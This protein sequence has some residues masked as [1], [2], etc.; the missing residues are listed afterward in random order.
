[1]DCSFTDLYPEHI[2]LVASLSCTAHAIVVIPR[3]CGAWR[4]AIIAQHEHL[5]RSVTLQRFP[6]LKSILDVEPTTLPFSEL[7]R[8]Q[9]V[10]EKA[11]K[12]AES[13][14][15]PTVDSYLFTITVE[16]QK[17]DYSQN[18]VVFQWSGKLKD[19]GQDCWATPSLWT[20]ATVPLWSQ[21][22]K[23]AWNRR[24]QESFVK[25]QVTRE[26]HTL[27]L[28]HTRIF[29]SDIDNHYIRYDFQGLPCWPFPKNIPY[30]PD[31]NVRVWSRTGIFTIWIDDNDG[32]VI[33]LDDFEVYLD[34]IFKNAQSR[35]HLCEQRFGI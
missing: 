24:W 20:A 16:T 27:Q 26:F 1:M 14:L 22:W 5:W 3:V 17:H 12:P 19:N 35:S 32:N 4:T 10:S 11:L 6:I 2:V 18:E 30:R 21:P 25:L 31:S 34:Y 8:R 28:L 29:D 7:Y 9:L 15:T 33:P 23:D 13:S